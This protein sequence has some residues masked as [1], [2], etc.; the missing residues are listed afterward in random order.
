M[1]L[2]IC[3]CFFLSLSVRVR[4]CVFVHLSVFGCS[5][6]RLFVRVC[7]SV[8]VS[9]SLSVAISLSIYLSLYVS[10]LIVYASI[11]F[12]VTLAVC[13]CFFVNLLS[14]PFPVYNCSLPIYCTCLR[15]FLCHL[16][17]LHLLNY[18]SICFAVSLSIYF[19]VFCTVSLSICES[20]SVF[21]SAF[22]L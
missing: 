6:V 1:Y 10:L 18:L 21:L 13:N 16:N 12:T 19:S 22:F 11:C 8:S 7:L 17:Y 9:L 15:L 20:V 5:S 14:A 2:D 4:L 3:T